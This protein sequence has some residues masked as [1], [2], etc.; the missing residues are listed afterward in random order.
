MA[1]TEYTT[2]LDDHLD[3]P[4]VVAP[5]DGPADTLDPE[6]RASSATPDKGAAAKAGYGTVNAVV[7]LPKRKV[8]AKGGDADRTETYEVEGPNGE[9]VKVTRNMDTGERKVG[10]SHAA[11]A[12]AGAK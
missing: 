12:K 2:T 10:G 1:D 11:P 5:G 7:K 9:P 8:V 4:S 6:E 3:A